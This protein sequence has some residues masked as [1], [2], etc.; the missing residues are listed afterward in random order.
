ME[1]RDDGA[2]AG[3]AAADGPAEAQRRGAMAVIEEVDADGQPQPT[4]EE[5]AQMEAMSEQWTASM[6][7]LAK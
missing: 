1:H 7:T 5:L 6:K 4:E 3:S 2:A